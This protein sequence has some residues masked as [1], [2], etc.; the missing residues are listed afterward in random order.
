MESLNEK[1]KELEERV[2]LLEDA[3]GNAG[4]GRYL[5]IKYWEEHGKK[6]E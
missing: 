1:I 3:H 2:K 5:Y 4:I 6:I